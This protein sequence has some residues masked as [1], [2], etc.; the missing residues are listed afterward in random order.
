MRRNRMLMLLISLLGLSCSMDERMT[1]Q[2]A[3]ARDL[4]YIGRAERDYRAKI[5]Q[6]GTIKE[7]EV[8]SLLSSRVVE[9]FQEGVAGYHFDITLDSKKASFSVRAI[10]DS[11]PTPSEM[12][13]YIDESLVLRGSAKANPSVNSPVFTDRLLQL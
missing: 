7:L 10:P 11:G 1:S 8:A 12:A 4:A 3:A 13:L 6:F 2:R 5:G 9:H